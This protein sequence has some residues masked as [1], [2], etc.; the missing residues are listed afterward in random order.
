M[1]NL[2]ITSTI[3]L[4]I[5]FSNNIYAQTNSFI[6]FFGH[7][8]YFIG[9]N[10][11]QSI[12]KTKCSIVAQ[13]KGVEY[14]FGCKNILQKKDEHTTSGSNDSY[15]DAASYENYITTNPNAL[16]LVT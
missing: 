11:Y 5:I 14:T 15:N 6:D 8:Y 1:K 3:F 10:C 9:I 7:K 13:N 2:L 4:S 16:L 12:H